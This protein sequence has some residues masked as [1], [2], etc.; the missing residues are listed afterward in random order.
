[1]ST[2][3]LLEEKKNLHA[4]LKTYERNFQAE[5]QRP[6]TKQEDIAPVSGE[7]RRYKDLKGLLAQ[8]KDQERLTRASKQT[9][10]AA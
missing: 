9:A 7:Y 1:M 4:Y 10:P 8:R 3:R 2:A 6:V 5:H